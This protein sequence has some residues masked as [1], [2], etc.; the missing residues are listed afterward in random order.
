MRIVYFLAIAI[1]LLPIAAQAQDEFTDADYR[2]FMDRYE[3][4]K[5]YLANHKQKEAVKILEELNQQDPN[6]ANIN[7]LL[8]VCYVKSGEN[9][10]KAITHLEKADDQ[11]KLIYDNPGIGAAQYV[12]Y[13]LTLAHCINHNC[14]KAQTAYE[15]FEE[16]YFTED[17]FYLEDARKK[18][19]DCK[20]KKEVKPEFRERLISTNHKVDTTHVEFTSEYTLWGVQVG[21]Y[22]EPK[23]TREFKGLKNVEAF[24][25]EN[26]VFRYVIG[27]FVL[28]SQAMK[29]LEQVRAAGYNDAF[30]VDINQ[31]DDKRFATEVTAVDH[32]PIHFEIRGHIDYRVQIGAFRDEIPDHISEMYLQIDGI[33]EYRQGDLTILMLGSFDNYESANIYRDALAQEGYTDAFV[34]AYNYKQRISLRQ[35]ADHLKEKSIAAD[36]IEE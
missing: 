4:A 13:Y 15:R 2:E 23:Y 29:L 6:E 34:T 5:I 35:A 28:R 32:E 10:N 1:A 24:V 36:D 31:K 18:V 21:A 7:Y 14:E 12:Y 33:E 11:F 30:I 25:D 22:L 26:G 27:N 19:A 3:D 8:G 17:A 20:A 16:E 9:I